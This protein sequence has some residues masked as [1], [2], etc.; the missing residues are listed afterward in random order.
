MDPVAAWK[1][2]TDALASGDHATAKE[3]AKALIDWI[4]KSGFNPIN[5]SHSGAVALLAFLAYELE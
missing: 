2:L 1:E 3:R 4:G 5:C